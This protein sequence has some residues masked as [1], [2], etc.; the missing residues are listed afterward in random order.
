MEIGVQ[1]ALILFIGSTCQ[2]PLILLLCFRWR[3]VWSSNKEVW[4]SWDTPPGCLPSLWL[5]WSSL[6]REELSWSQVRAKSQCLPENLLPGNLVV[7]GDN[8]NSIFPNIYIYEDKY[9]TDCSLSCITAFIELQT[10]IPSKISKNVLIIQAALYV[11]NNYYRVLSVTIEIYP[12][13]LI[14][15][16]LPRLGR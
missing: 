3:R 4:V 8:K 6:D 9:I 12:V 14:G 7:N 13:Y 5:P 10:I 11:E 1:N 16:Q 2:V 15:M